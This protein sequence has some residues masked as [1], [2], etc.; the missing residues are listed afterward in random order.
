I[1]AAGA[2]ADLVLVCLHN[3][4]WK[5]DWGDLP[6]WFIDLGRLLVDRGADMVVGHGV[7]VLQR[8]VFHR[9]RPIFGSLGNFIFHTARAA[10]YDRER[11]EVWSGAVCRCRFEDGACSGIDILPVAVGRPEPG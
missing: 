7:P 5:A 4:H 1:E 8:I 9:G 11:V 3:H 6:D 10:T 2:E